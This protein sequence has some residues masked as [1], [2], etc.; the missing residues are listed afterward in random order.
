[1]LYR[2]KKTDIA[3]ILFVNALLNG[4]ATI[5]LSKKGPTHL[6]TDQ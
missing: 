6:P 1:M 4:E 5:C 3:D 2:R